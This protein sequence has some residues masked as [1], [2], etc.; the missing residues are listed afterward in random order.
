MASY[1]NAALKILDKHNISVHP[2]YSH[3]ELVN[4]KTQNVLGYIK[5]P[6]ELVR[7]AKTVQSN[8]MNNSYQ[9]A[10]AA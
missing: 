3:Y 1:V 10:Q 7:Y 2:A 6:E 9:A 4:R 5:G 8:S